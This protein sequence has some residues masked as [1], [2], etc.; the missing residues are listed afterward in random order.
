MTEFIKCVWW[1]GLPTPPSPPLGK[2][3]VLFGTPH[4]N[5]IITKHD[6]SHDF[7]KGV[8]VIAVVSCPIKRPVA[9]EVKVTLF[10]LSI[11]CT[12]Q[13]RCENIGLFR[14]PITLRR[15]LSNLVTLGGMAVKLGRSEAENRSSINRKTPIV[16]AFDKS[17]T[18]FRNLVLLAKKNK[19][20]VIPMGS[21]NGHNYAKLPIN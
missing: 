7:L 3:W 1:H 2:M 10:I 8:R 14:N 15:H 18:N 4:W 6:N 19:S 9:P 20:R 16:F 21:S 13:F 12:D 11:G 5:T 17:I